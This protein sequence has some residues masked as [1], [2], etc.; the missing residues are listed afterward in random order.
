MTRSTEPPIARPRSTAAS[1]ASRR[2]GAKSRGPKS[3]VGKARAA[4]NALRHGLRASDPV[5]PDA[6]PPWMSAKLA[7]LETA[8]GDIGQTRREHF[9]RY[10]LH[11]LLIEK[12]DRLIAAEFARMLAT[13][14]G[15]DT[16]QLTV[17]AA[18][19]DLSQ[20]RALFGYRRRF[21]AAR[22]RSLVKLAT[23][24]PWLKQLRVAERKARA[25]MA[26]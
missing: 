17:P 2:N 16:V 12:V 18:D 22:D 8:L 7:D 14:D 26:D 3:A 6:M 13:S 21:R 11:L 24:G 1:A 23:Q 9:D 15:G 19:V 10:A 20:L 25:D 5:L 4:R